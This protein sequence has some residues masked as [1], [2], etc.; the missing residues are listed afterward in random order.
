MFGIGLPYKVFFAMIAFEN[1]NGLD[2]SVESCGGP[3]SIQA[4]SSN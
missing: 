3:S 4:L 1:T 2:V